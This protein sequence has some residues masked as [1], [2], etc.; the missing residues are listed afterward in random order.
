M[1]RVPKLLLAGSIAA[2]ALV[3]SPDASRADNGQVAAGIIGGLR[4]ELCLARL[5]R[6]RPP[7]MLPH[8]FTSPR[9]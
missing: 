2:I 8:L 5:L 9:P 1:R 3:A 7:I 6:N 4:W